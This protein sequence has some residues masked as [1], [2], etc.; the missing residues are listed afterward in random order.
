MKAIRVHAF[1]G[2]EV[3]RLEEVPAPGA[4]GKIVLVP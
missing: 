4:Y 2:P 1:G 3:M